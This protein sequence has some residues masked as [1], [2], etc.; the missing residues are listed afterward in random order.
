MITPEQE[1]FDNSAWITSTP[2]PVTRSFP[3]YV[4]ETGRFY[5]K[6]DYSVKRNFHDSYILLYTHNGIGELKTGGNKIS[7]PSGHAV[8]LDCHTAHEYCSACE[9]WDFSWIHF[10]GNGIENLFGIIYP[11]NSVKSVSVKHRR[12]FEKNIE[13]LQHNVCKNDIKSSI[14]VSSCMHEIVSSLYSSMLVSDNSK[15]ESTN[16]IKS[17]VRFIEENYRN[18]ITVDDM[19]DLIHISK[20]HFI[21]RFR[22]IMGVTPYHY[23]SAYRI[24]VAKKLLRTTDKSVSEISEECGFADTSNFIARF[25]KHTGQKPLGYRRDFT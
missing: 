1:F 10:S 9:L 25:K 7:L 17:V 21:R 23:L 13:A 18:P 3:F 6:T 14:E 12:I 5:A 16:D 24:T 2:T 22:M 15:S 8:I 20:Y 11:D 4:T 19:V